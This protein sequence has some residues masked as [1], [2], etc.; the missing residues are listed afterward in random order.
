MASGYGFEVH[1][2]TRGSW[3]FAFFTGGGKSAANQSQTCVD[4]NLAHDV[5]FIDISFEEGV[6]KG[7]VPLDE[8]FVLLHIQQLTSTR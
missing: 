2:L 3:H 4:M 5:L 8:S 7:I 1:L 6:L